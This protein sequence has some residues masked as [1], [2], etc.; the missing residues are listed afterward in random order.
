MAARLVA[1]IAETF[2]AGRRIMPHCSLD[3]AARKVPQR[4]LDEPFFVSIAMRII[5]LGR[6]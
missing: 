3:V 1:G 6:L 4:S 2:V 5:V